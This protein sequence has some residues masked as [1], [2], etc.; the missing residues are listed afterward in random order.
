MWA[1]HMQARVADVAEMVVRLAPE[2]DA[3]ATMSER[4]LFHRNLAH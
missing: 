4:G 3:H 1:Y 2:A